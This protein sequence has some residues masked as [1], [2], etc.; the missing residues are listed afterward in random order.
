MAKP[1]MVITG[2]LQ[3]VDPKKLI[4]KGLLEV[5]LADS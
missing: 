5:N 3:N 4:P 2:R 1:P